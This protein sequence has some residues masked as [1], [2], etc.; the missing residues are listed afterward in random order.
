MHF[1]QGSQF[2]YKGIG[3]LKAK[4]WKKYIMQMPIEKS[5]V[6]IL[7]NKADFRTRNISGI[8]HEKNI[9]K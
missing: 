4:Y 7:I 6:A 5:G 2:N 8:L 3:W 9:T 1:L